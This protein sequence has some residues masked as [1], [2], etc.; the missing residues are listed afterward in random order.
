M[1]DKQELVE[2]IFHRGRRVPEFQGIKIL[3]PDDMNVFAVQEMLK[4]TAEFWS[5]LGC[6]V[7]SLAPEAEDDGQSG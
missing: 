1:T 5:S 4:Q 2:T 3:I 7:Y 6:Q